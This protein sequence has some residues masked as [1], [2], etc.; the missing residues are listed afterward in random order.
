[1]EGAAGPQ[2]R[3]TREQQ[4]LLLLLHLGYKR[5]KKTGKASPS[6]PFPVGERA[7]AS[8]LG[9]SQ[10]VTLGKQRSL[11]KPAFST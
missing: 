7:W 1:M 5:A 9:M 3:A 4:A 8:G 2:T 6:D 11:S 10:C